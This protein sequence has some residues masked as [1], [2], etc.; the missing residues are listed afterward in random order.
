MIPESFLT[1][2]VVEKKG[3][4]SSMNSPV[5][6]I[7]APCSMPFG[8]DSEPTVAQSRVPAASPCTPSAVPANWNHS[9]VYHCPMRGATWLP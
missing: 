5:S 6:T 4:R 7:G 1:I 8:A 3:V 9:I 2:Q